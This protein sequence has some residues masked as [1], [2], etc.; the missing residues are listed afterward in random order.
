MINLDRDDG[1]LTPGTPVAYERVTGYRRWEDR[2][3]LCRWGP[4]KCDGDCNGS[5]EVVETTM[6]EVVN[7]ADNSVEAK[8]TNDH[9][10]TLIAAFEDAC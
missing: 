10:H 1:E 3:L 9:R 5:R 6:A 8:L 2:P 7:Y 4:C